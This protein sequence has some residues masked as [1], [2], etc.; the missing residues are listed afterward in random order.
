MLRVLLNESGRNLKDLA[1]RAVFVIF[2]EAVLVNRGPLLN[3]FQ[4]KNAV[5]NSVIQVFT[6]ILLNGF[7]YN[8]FIL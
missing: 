6:R 8:L 1:P 2:W 3:K 4:I 5:G 7:N